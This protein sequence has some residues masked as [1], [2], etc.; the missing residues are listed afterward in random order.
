ML[1][2]ATP[3]LCQSRVCGPVVDVVEQ[4]RSETKADVAFIHQEIYKDNQV[5][6]GPA[7]QVAAWRL[8]S[9]P[10]IFVID[11]NGGVRTRIEG[12]I[13]AGELQRAVAEVA[14]SSS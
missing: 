11:R 7:P 5:E 8:P 13:S 10:W 6:Q 2:F 12:A 1:I 9:E 4:V 3:L 14:G